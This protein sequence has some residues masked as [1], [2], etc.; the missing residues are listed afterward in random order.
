MKRTR[1]A[2]LLVFGMLAALLPM[3]AVPAAGPVVVP[4]LVINEIIQNPAAVFDSAGEWF[5]LFNPNASVVDIDGWTL[6][7]PRLGQPHDHQRRPAADPRRRLPGAGH[8]RRHAHQRRRH[9]RLRV[10]ELHPRQRR[11]RG[12]PP[13]RASASRSTASSTTAARPSRIRPA[14]RW[15]WPT[16][17]STT[18]S[19]P[20]GAPPRRPTATATWAR[21][22]RRTTAAC[23]RSASW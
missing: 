12:H 23:C 9:R 22:G 6:R 18:T 19:A 7:G 21:R 13:R 10:L 4:E 15:R 5:E 17:R 14:P 2:L 3:A 16:R 20:T 8:Q 1:L 11:R